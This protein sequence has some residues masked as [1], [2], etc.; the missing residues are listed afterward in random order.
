M[1]KHGRCGCQNIK[2]RC[3]DSRGL[4]RR[5]EAHAQ[6]TPSQ[7]GTTVGSVYDERTHPDHHGTYDS[8][9]SARL[10]TKRRRQSSQVCR[11]S[12]HGFT[13]KYIYWNSL[14]IDLLI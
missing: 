3:Y 12:R 9:S 11:T 13:G 4:L 5:S 8:R 1:E 14:N 7:A 10:L 6:T 2:A